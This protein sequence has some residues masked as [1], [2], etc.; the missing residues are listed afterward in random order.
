[1]I[2]YLTPL[3]GKKEYKQNQWV[4]AQQALTMLLWNK[5]SAL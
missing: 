5:D 2:H 3:S 1:M 4:L